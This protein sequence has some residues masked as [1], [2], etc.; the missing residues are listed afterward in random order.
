MC[1]DTRTKCTIDQKNGFKIFTIDEDGSLQSTFRST[2]VKGLKY[3]PNE[4]IRVNPEEATF[5]A[6]ENIGHAITIAREGTR[7]WAMVSNNIIVLPVT[8]F[9]VVA[10]G[11]Y[12]KRS[13]DIQS[14]DGYY[15]AFEAKEIIV[16]DNPENRNIFQDYLIKT[17]ISRQK[18]GMSKIEKD[19]FQNRLPQ[20][21]DALQ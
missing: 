11:T 6:F 18:H 13:D 8:C 20:F 9:E 7:K 1:L 15:P 21:A 5:F 16:H 19:A 12:R 4:K 3:P 17:W 14:M 10:T 2:F